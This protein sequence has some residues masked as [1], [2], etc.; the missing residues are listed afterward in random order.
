MLRFPESD[1][2]AAS[3]LRGQGAGRAC[4]AAQPWQWCWCGVPWRTWW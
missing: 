2:G 4:A 3:F 1:F